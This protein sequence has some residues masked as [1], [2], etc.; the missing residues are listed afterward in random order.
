MKKAITL[1]AVLLFLSVTTQAQNT[2]TRKISEFSSI[3]VGEA[4][5]LTLIPS[6]IN[7]AL[8]KAE[9]ID[10]NDINTNVSGGKLKIELDGNSYKSINVEIE[11]KY[12]AINSLSVSSAATVST[13]GTLKSLQ[14]DI[15]VSS[16]GDANL[17]VD[18]G[19]LDIDI[20]SS[21][22]LNLEGR[23]TSQRVEVS[24]AG[25]Y[26]GYD[27]MSES[28]YVRASSAGSARV[29]VSKEIDAKA[30]SGGGVKYKGNPDKVY[31]SSSSG[32]D[33]H[34]SN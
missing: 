33:V 27:L 29:N 21:G 5:K 20:S 13:K 1:Y 19:E 2:E 18:A 15:K 12:K 7:E 31:V 34:K 3:S 30:S 11:L 9:N 22:D 32:G 14:L 25:S 6:N 16:A 17:E 24:S 4:I 23:A 10:L 8:I 28:A 26:D